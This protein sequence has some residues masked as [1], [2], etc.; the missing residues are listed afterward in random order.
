MVERK[1]LFMAGIVAV[2]LGLS[3]ASPS[4]ASDHDRNRLI[5]RIVAKADPKVMEVLVT[6]RDAR[7]RPTFQTIKV[8]TVERAKEVI[9]GLLG[10]PGVRGVEM[11]RKVQALANDPGYSQ[12]WAL[13]SSFLDFYKI[14]SMTKNDTSSPNIAVID[15]GVQG[16][17]PDLA[18]SMSSGYSHITTCGLLSCRVAAGT[19]SST[20]ANDDFGHGTHVAGIIAAE[21]NN[22]QGVVGLAQRVRIR[23]VKVLG[24]DGSGYTDDV[25]SGIVWAAD[26]AGVLNMSFGAN[27]PSDAEEAAVN[28][29][30]KKGRVLVAAAGN[31][32][33]TCSTPSY[34]AGYRGVLGV[35]AYDE[36]GAV[37]SFSSRGSQVD[38]IAP[39]VNILSTYP[40]SRYA[41]MDGTSM[42]TPF[43]SAEAALAK[44]HCGWSG[45]KARLA[46]MS[47]AGHPDWRSN[48]SGYGK[49]HPD[50]LL[51]C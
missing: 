48:S 8:P 15:S 35:G 39:G 4:A 42:A 12:Q 17:H 50:R 23:S 10:K 21:L 32:D 34:P 28:Y 46:I 9:G 25:A 13:S 2:G 41:S 31:C 29:A 51:R 14:R 11:N 27:G 43:V 5:D 36:D 26:H 19:T 49:I 7:G 1:R 47:T 16:N 3:T 30:R 20:T 38:V 45:D 6:R 37:A 44:Q 40:G 24:S 22:N 33:P 18:H